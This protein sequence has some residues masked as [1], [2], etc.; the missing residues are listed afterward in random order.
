MLFELYLN[1]R[2]STN[3]FAFSIS[4]SPKH[5]INYNYNKEL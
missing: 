4:L 3:G 5:V 1:T 2:K